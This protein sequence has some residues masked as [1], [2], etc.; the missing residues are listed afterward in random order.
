MYS[1]CHFERSREIFSIGLRDVRPHFYI[2]ILFS[3]C[4]FST[5]SA[6][7]SCEQNMKQAD[8]LYAG[9]DYDN[10]VQLLEKTLEDCDLSKK[11][12]E[13]ILELLAKAYLEQDNLVQAEKT[14]YKLLKNNPLYESKENND[15]EN[16]D[17]L[18]KKFDIHPQF[19]IGLRNTG[20]QPQFKSTKTY[21]IL[22]DL[23]YNVPYQTKK[24][25]LLYYLI[26]EY[27]FKKNLSLNTDIINFNISYNRSFTR[28]PD[29]KMNY[30][31]QLS[32]IE[33]P[34]YLKKYFFT[35][36]NV[37]AYASLG[38]GY[39]RMLQAKGTADIYYPDEDIYTGHKTDYV[40]VEVADMLPQRNKNSYEWL[41]GIGV[42]FKFKNLGIYFN[43]RYSG[44]INSL[45]SA[46]KRYD[47]NVL[48]NDYFY[49][50]N[51]IKM[52]KYE[53]GLSISYTLKNVIKK[54]R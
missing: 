42:G 51:S 2:L 36:K 40:S 41:A 47:N 17:V 19:S 8:E 10:C 4:C 25:V 1:T 44:G 45:T 23:D 46:A 48:V 28:R 12:K 54:V 52:N 43:A 50:D 22:D 15:H 53:I 39:M 33:V 26:L 27:E 29:W 37:S 31:E 35:E 11:K 32:F 49:V 9:G 24:T 5:M 6:Q 30:M 38:V 18:V 3:I 16:F 13:I 34:L 21:S 20:M 7:N 14:V